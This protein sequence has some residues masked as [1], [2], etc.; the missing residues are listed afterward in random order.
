ML[1]YW[2]TCFDEPTFGPTFIF[3]D[4]WEEFFCNFVDSTS[5][6][7]L[8]ASVVLTVGTVDHATTPISCLAVLTSFLV[9]MQTIDHLLTRAEGNKSAVW[10]M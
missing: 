5:W 1:Y 7:H 8:V 3:H 9:V 4:W 6:L 10:F 2:A